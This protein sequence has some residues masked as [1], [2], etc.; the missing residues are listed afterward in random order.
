MCV[1]LGIEVLMKTIFIHGNNEL[2]CVCVRVIIVV[3]KLL[4]NIL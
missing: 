1:A 3:L 4:T 2:F